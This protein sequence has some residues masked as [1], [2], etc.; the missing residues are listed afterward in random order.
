MSSPDEQRTLIDEIDERQEAL[1]NDLSSLNARVEALLNDCLAAREEQRKAEEE[2]VD[3]PSS[4]VGPNVQ[5]SQSPAA[6][7]TPQE[8]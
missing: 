6:I 3:G 1:L 5:I 2:I 7:S 8:C 4:L